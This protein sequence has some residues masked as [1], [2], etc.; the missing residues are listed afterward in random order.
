MA[1]D[2]AGLLGEPYHTPSMV[3]ELNKSKAEVA[4]P[5]IHKSRV[6]KR[7]GKEL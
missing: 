3:E 2:V 7:N 1:A 4:K 5:D 6:H